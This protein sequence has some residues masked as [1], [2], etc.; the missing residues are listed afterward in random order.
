[1]GEQHTASRRARVDRQRNTEMRF[2][3]PRPTHKQDVHRL[4]QEGQAG[5]LAYSSRREAGLEVEV[6]LLQRVQDRKA[7][8]S[9]TGV[10]RTVGFIGELQFDEPSKI[11]GEA[12]LALGRAVR[13]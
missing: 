1:M 10:D 13:F 12:R 11:R 3:D 4:I 9:N 8:S 2:S 7:R 5:Q 6:E